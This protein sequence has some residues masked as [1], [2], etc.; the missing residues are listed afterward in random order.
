MS[1]DHL[2]VQPEFG[3]NGHGSQVLQEELCWSQKKVSIQMSE[4][5][6]STGGAA[7]LC[8][9]HAS[10]P[11]P[12]SCDT[13]AILDRQLKRIFHHCV[14]GRRAEPSD[15]FF[16][17]LSIT[18]DVAKSELDLSLSPRTSMGLLKML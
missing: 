14:E 8:G 12:S 13:G 2:S 3:R 15:V 11:V 4:E 10:H 9:E 18:F 17:D 7:F 5:E 16:Q 1:G 6:N